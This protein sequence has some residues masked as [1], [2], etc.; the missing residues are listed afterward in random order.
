MLL[1]ECRASACNVYASEWS[2]TKE[3]CRKQSVVLSYSVNI[4]SIRNYWINS[5]NFYDIVVKFTAKLPWSKFYARSWFYSFKYLKISIEKLL[6]FCVYSYNSF[7]VAYLV[8][9]L[10]YMAINF[11]KNYTHTNIFRWHIS[12]VCKLYSVPNTMYHHGS[13]HVSLSTHLFPS[14]LH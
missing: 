10:I 9:Q 12:V 13:C 5:N 6:T 8:V 14:F 3:L 1:C 11:F 4:L 7:R 2:K